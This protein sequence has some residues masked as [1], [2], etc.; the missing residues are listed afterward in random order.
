MKI[1]KR[2]L[3]QLI[4]EE[5]E[6]TIDEMAFSMGDLE[7]AKGEVEASDSR[8]QGEQ[9]QEE[10]MKLMAYFV[11]ALNKVGGEA[12]VKKGTVTPRDIKNGAIDPYNS[13]LAVI[14]KVLE[15][16]GAKMLQ[17]AKGRTVRLMPLSWDKSNEYKNAFTTSGDGP[18]RFHDHARELLSVLKSIVTFAHKTGKVNAPGH[19][20]PYLSA[21]NGQQLG[22]MLDNI[23]RTAPYGKKLEDPQAFRN[24]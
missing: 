13:D 9:N 10:F 5:I 3:K 17:G 8:A 23:R 19:E 11:N 2:Q 14:Y 15:G 24:R 7:T 22:Q 12:V 21:E 1:T 20:E 16:V 6:S 18:A 4:K